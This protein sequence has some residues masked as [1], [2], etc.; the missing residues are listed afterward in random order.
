MCVSVNDAVCHGIPSKKEILKNGDIV[1]VDVTTILDGY[2]AD[3]SRMYIIGEASDK[4]KKLVSVAKECLEKAISIIK[5]WETRLGDLGEVIVKHAKEKAGFVALTTNPLLPF[6]ALKTK[7]PGTSTGCGTTA[8]A[9]ATGVAGA[10]T[11]VGTS[12]TISG[13]TTET[14]S[15]TGAAASTGSTF[16]SSDTTS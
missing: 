3:A 8:A 11:E 12:V 9:S 15:T 5:P 10:T 14:G 6:E 4:A 16:V 1:N 7:P 2:Y 13:K